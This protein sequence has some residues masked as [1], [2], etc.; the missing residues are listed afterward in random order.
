MKAVCTAFAHAHATHGKREKREML[1][2]QSADPQ[3]ELEYKNMVSVLVHDRV[4][5]S[6]E[7]SV[8]QRWQP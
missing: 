7:R 4:V 2:A 5:H 6:V 3:I 1:K 8:R